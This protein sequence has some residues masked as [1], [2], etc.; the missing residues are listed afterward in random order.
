MSRTRSFAILI[1]ATM[2]MGK[3][4]R[5]LTMGLILLISSYCVAQTSSSTLPA[6]VV[7]VENINLLPH[8]TTVDQHYIG[9][10]RTLLDIFAEREGYRFIYRPLPLNDLITQT[11]SLQVDFKYPDHPQWKKELKQGHKL[12]YSEPVISYVEGVMVLP[13]RVNRGAQQ[14]KSLALVMGYTP[15]PY[16]EKIKSDKIVLHETNSNEE[17]IELVALGRVDGL[18]TNIGVSNYQLRH[19]IKREGAVLFDTNLPHIYDY[20]HLSSIKHPEVIIRL[21][22]FLLE[23]RAL[24]REIKRIHG[25]E[26]LF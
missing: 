26:G 16:L 11:L 18:Y 19:I 4:M 22:D 1:G 12:V 21:N 9:F 7:G 8:Y 13:G 14:L 24:I 23:N 17:A 3:A 15:W 6:F 2:T 20:Y 10:A 25:L 5:T